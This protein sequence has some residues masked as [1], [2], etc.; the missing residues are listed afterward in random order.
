MKKSKGRVLGEGKYLRLLDRDGWEYVERHS[1]R[2]I[3]AI[4]AITAD[5]QLV[6]VEQL[7]RAL[8][9]RVIELPAGLVG[10]LAGAEHEDLAVA[11]RRELLEETGYAATRLEFLFHS[12]LSSGL[13]SSLITFFRAYGLKKIHAGGGDESEDIVVHEVPLAE[14]DA[15]LAAQRVR[16]CYVDPRLYVALHLA[17]RD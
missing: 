11:A 17:A 3:V 7:R 5:R 1:I 2:G 6:L 4:I 14:A 13:S 15:W 10:D 12:P 9:A 8:D 16:G